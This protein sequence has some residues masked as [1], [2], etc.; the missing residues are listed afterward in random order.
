MHI[1]MAREP[2]QKEIGLAKATKHY[3]VSIEGLPSA[4]VHDIVIRDDGARALVASLRHD[5]VE[6][7]MLDG[8][9]VRPGQ[10]FEQVPQTA[11]LSIGSH[12]F[13]RVVNALCDPLDDKGAFP[14]KNTDLVLQREAGDIASREA[15]TE[16]LLT[17]YMMTDTVLPIGRGQRQLFMG[18]VHSGMDAFCREIIKNQA[19]QN[20]VCIYVTVG[21]TPEQV[22]RLAA[23]MFAEGTSAEYTCIIAGTSEDSA[24]MNIIAPSVGLLAAEQFCDEGRDVL[25]VIDDLY[26]HAKYLREIALL[27][28]QLPGRESYPGDI[29]FQQAHLIERAGNFVGKASITLLP[30]LQTDMES[31]TDL[32]MTNIMGTTDGHT[33]FSSV[34]YAQGTFP[35]VHDDESVTRVGKHT[36]SIVQKQLSTAVTSL[37]SD[38]KEQERFARFG[39]QLSEASRAVINMG[40]IMRA[41][42]NQTEGVRLYRDVQVVLLSLV[43]TTFVNKKDVAFFQKYFDTLCATIHDDK[44]MQKVREQV[45]SGKDF[46][47]FIKEVEKNTALLNKACR[48]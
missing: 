13:G 35:P 23:S 2:L 20:M 5:A 29:F 21:K 42:L 26:T 41:L 40:E 45:M 39:T 36:Q 31:Y 17:G 34:D 47:S 7:M 15:I 10:R 16:Q 32:I 48:Q 9:D 24:P 46:N 37:L 3:L 22:E 27:E 44:K 25:L 1:L 4:R 6:A 18:P 12:L 8:V 11:Q 33:S 43:F 38:A 28:G 14:P 19:N 30:L